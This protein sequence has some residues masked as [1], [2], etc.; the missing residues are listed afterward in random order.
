MMNFVS[1]SIAYSQL[2]NFKFD[3]N[4][5]AALLYAI[6]NNLFSNPSDIYIDEY[7]QKI[8]F[9]LDSNINQWSF[10]ESQSMEPNVNIG[11]VIFILS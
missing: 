1:N 5:P 10:I 11:M 4:S 3:Q 7:A 8:I 9:A 6:D 2:Y